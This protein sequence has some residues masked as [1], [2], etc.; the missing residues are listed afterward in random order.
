MKKKLLATLLVLCMIL[1]SFGGLSALALDIIDMGDNATLISDN[2]YNKIHFYFDDPDNATIDDAAELQQATAAVKGDYAAALM[3]VD[4]ESEVNENVYIT[5]QFASDYMETAEYE[6]FKAALENATTPEM[7]DTVKTPRNTFSKR[8]HAAIIEENM[9]LLA[10]ISYTAARSVPYSS[11]VRLIVPKAQ[12]DQEVLLN[13]VKNDNIV[14]LSV[15]GEIEFVTSDINDETDSLAIDLQEIADDLTY[16]GAGVKIGVYETTTFPLEFDDGSTMPWTNLL[17]LSCPNLYSFSNIPIASQYDIGTLPDTA[18]DGA[19]SHGTM[20]VS[21]FASL[22]PDAQIYYTLV[23]LD[24]DYGAGLGY[25]I[26]QGCDIVN[27]SFGINDSTGYQYRFDVDG[28]FDEQIK[29]HGLV[30]VV[31]AG[32]V[33]VDLTNTELK[34]VTSPGLAYNAIT[35]GGVAYSAAYNGYI[36]DNGACYITTANMTKPN[37]SAPFTVTLPNIGSVSGTSFSAPYVAAAVAMLI[38]KTLP[39]NQYRGHPEH[40]ASALIATADR[41]EDFTSSA[42][43]DTKVGAVVVNITRLL[44]ESQIPVYVNNSTGAQGDYVIN[45][46]VSLTQGQ[47]IQIGLSWLA[48][49]DASEETRYSTNY[50]LYIYNSANQ[51]V[52]A[53]GCMVST[54]EKIQYTASQSG[55]YYIRVLQSSTRNQLDR[56]ALTYNIS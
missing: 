50:N 55:T 8:Y 45:H 15:S 17:D 40:V 32:N 44:D 30:V 19:V 5:V 29:T 37:I 52:A 31:S 33:T 10:D 25:F 1:P 39:S 35:V 34:Y 23:A 12:L 49:V 56:L 6:V 13:V 18:A 48:E 26:E 36:H 53:S 22:V 4:G 43:I 20:V 54:F 11:F 28:V 27:C 7:R 21:V 42:S 46:T 3:A 14:H 24:N 2:P 9:P 47:T 38:D 16:T 41:T 51:A